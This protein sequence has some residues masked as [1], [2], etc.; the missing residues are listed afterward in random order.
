MLKRRVSLLRFLCI[1]GQAGVLRELGELLTDQSD[2]HK[3]YLLNTWVLFL[4]TFYISLSTLPTTEVACP[5]EISH[6]SISPP[7]AAR[8]ALARTRYPVPFRGGKKR[9]L[10]STVCACA[11]FVR[12]FVISD[13]Q[14]Y[15]GGD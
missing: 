6:I 4:V 12:E 10:V 7:P 1:L 3:E 2:K 14:T 13:V 15:M 8:Y 5:L 9:A 11:R